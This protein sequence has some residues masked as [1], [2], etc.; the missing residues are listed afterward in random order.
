[1]ILLRRTNRKS[2]SLRSLRFTSR[3]SSSSMFA[4]KSSDLG[5]TYLT[6]LIKTHKQSSLLVKLS[7]CLYS[8]THDTFAEKP[9]K[10]QAVVVFLNEYF[11]VF[12]K[13]KLLFNFI[14]PTVNLPRFAHYDLLQGIPSVSCSSLNPQI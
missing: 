4:T 3:Y 8:L 12:D 6:T 14:E 13:V 10:R 7:V 11:I 1:M 5:L 2:N 9:K